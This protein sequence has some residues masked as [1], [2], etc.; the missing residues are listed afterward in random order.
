MAATLTP[1]MLIDA[2]S[3][4][5]VTP[6]GTGDLNQVN[7]RYS[8][9]T[10]GPQSWRLAP[11]KVEISSGGK[12]AKG[13]GPW[14]ELSSTSWTNPGKAD[15]QIV[16]AHLYSLSKSTGAYTDRVRWGGSLGHAAQLWVWAG[17]AGG[18]VTNRTPSQPAGWSSIGGG[19]RFGNHYADNQAPNG[20]GFIRI[21]G[22]PMSWTGTNGFFWTSTD[23]NVDNAAP[24]INKLNDL[25]GMVMVVEY[26]VVGDAAAV[27]ASKF[28]LSVGVDSYWEGL[29]TTGL[30]PGART[31]SGTGFQALNP[32]G[33]VVVFS[34]LSR[35]QID[36]H[37]LTVYPGWNG[38]TV[39]TPPPPPVDADKKHDVAVRTT[40]DII[41][42][43][44][45]VSSTVAVTKAVSV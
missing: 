36:A 3:K 38:G 43:G 35:A 1:Q 30:P 10:A 7:P 2:I 23:P 13:F 33:G 11:G 40:T 14:M 45:V 12:Y 37:P 15:V 4:P 17:G 16:D 34:T 25:D 9:T 27:A 6:V 39:V 31:G 32:N 41:V 21:H 20:D 24:D 18:T 22:W 8:E 29:G 26:K 44:N 28:A 42:D 5:G 19:Q